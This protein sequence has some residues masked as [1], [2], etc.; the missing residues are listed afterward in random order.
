MEKSD[1]VIKVTNLTKKYENLT[2]VN[3]ISFN[4]NKKEIFGFLGPNGAGKST[5]IGMLTTITA[6]TSGSALVNDFDISEQRNDVRRSIGIIFQDPSLDDHLTAQENLYFHARLYGISKKD[7]KER[8]KQVLDLM[9]LYD[10]KDEIIKNYSGGMRRRLEI[11]R[12]LIHHPK[13]LFLDEPTIGLDPQTRVHIWTYLL[14]LKKNHDMTIFLT[15]HYM[16]EAEYCDRIAIMDHGKIISLDTPS[17]LKAQ[18]GKDIIIIKSDDMDAL[19]KELTEK[20]NIELTEDNGNFLIHTIDSNQLMPQLFNKLET[21][22][23][24]IEVRRPTLDDVFLRLTGNR[25][26]DDQAES[27]AGLRFK[28]RNRQ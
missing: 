27:L 12:G 28:A 5:T 23:S 3:S 21:K 7:Y 26:R 11:A 25:I 4:V 18:T 20:M 24:H 17:N 10:R 14:E 9:D 16:D 6:P 2:A 22:I 19:K 1:T 15:T 13:I 8:L